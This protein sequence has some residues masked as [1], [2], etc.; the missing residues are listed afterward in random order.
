MRE[1]GRRS[2]LQPHMLYNVVGPLRHAL[3][4]HEAIHDFKII[5]SWKMHD[6]GLKRHYF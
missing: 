1:K 5:K 2:V 3:A 6:L 4:I